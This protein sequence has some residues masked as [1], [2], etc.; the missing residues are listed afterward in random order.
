LIVAA[1]DDAESGQSITIM[2]PNDKGG[3]SL[4]KTLLDIFPDAISE[5]KN[6]ARY[7]TLTKTDYTSES[8]KKI[9]NVWREY[10]RVQYVES[11]GY[12]SMPGVFGWNKID[13]GS[14]T[15]C[16]HLPP[17]KGIGADF[18]CGYG[19]L[20]DFVLRENSEIQ[21]IYVFDID[22]RAV[23]SCRKNVSDSRAKI[24]V[25]DCACPIPNLPPLDFIIMNPPF[26]NGSKEDKEL[27]QKFIETAAHHLKK[28]GHLYMVANAHLPYEKTLHEHFDTVEK[29][30]EGQ[31]FKIFKT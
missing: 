25:E 31:G 23:E 11:I 28:T 14:M 20:T 5:S 9:L 15:L 27:G 29:L 6:K 24:A 26:H 3:K 19:Y 21:T 16:E 30:Y 12:Y 10:G 17:L 13:K 8:L 22:A 4:E 7:I 1:W 2:Q 18:G